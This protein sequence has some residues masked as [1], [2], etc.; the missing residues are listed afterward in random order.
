MTDQPA[1]DPFER[2]EHDARRRAWI[3]GVATAA[4]VGGLVVVGTVAAPPEA[5]E[6][7][8]FLGLV[9]AVVVLSV[10]MPLLSNYAMARTIRRLR[11]F[12]PRVA[13]AGYRTGRGI[14]LVFRDGLVVSLPGAFAMCL[15]FFAASGE[16]VHPSFAEAARWWRTRG[17]R[18]V[19]IVGGRTGPPQARTEFEALRSRLG[20]GLAMCQVRQRTSEWRDANAPHWIVVAALTGPVPIPILPFNLNRVL[21][22]RSAIEAFLR[23]TLRSVTGVGT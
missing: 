8:T 3:G 10:S 9:A 16:V 19:A 23:N 5:G 12:A 18:R 6:Y 1:S 14:V 7:P 20:G 4:M 2:L 11:P 22:E 21:P 15:M 17:T 13:D